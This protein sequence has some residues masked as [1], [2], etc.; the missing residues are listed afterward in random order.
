MRQNETMRESIQTTAAE[1]TGR[2]SYAIVED[3]D[4]IEVNYEH[5]VPIFVVSH[6]LPNRQT[7]ENERLTII[8]VNDGVERAVPMANQAAGDKNVN[9]F[10]EANIGK[11][12]QEAGLADELHVEIMQILLCGGLRF[13][14]GLE[15]APVRLECIKMLE[16]PKG[17]THLRFKIEK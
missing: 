14:E 10:G 9:I 2:N 5:Q 4:T 8:F 3:P 16:L 13:F 12:V 11:Q 6:N 15:N 1:V 7:K 17:S